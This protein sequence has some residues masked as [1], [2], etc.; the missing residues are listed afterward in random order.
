MV[1]RGSPNIRPAA[2]PAQLVPERPATEPAKPGVEHDTAAP[3]PQKTAD[4]SDVGRPLDLLAQQHTEPRSGLQEGSKPICSHNTQAAMAQLKGQQG[5]E[6]EA[7]PELRSAW[8]APD[9]S[10]KWLPR[11]EEDRRGAWQNARRDVRP[12]TD[13]EVIMPSYDTTK[14]ASVGSQTADTAT[15]MLSSRGRKG[16]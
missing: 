3:L 5:A 2:A 9:S 13:T 7:P 15:A 10:N 6:N 16:I 8:A 1:P 12:T 4:T 14:V 11:P